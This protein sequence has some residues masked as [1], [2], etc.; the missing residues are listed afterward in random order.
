MK[1]AHVYNIYR[2]MDVRSLQ[3]LLDVLDAE[4]DAQAKNQPVEYDGGR[5]RQ[6]PEC[7]NLR[8]STGMSHDARF[9]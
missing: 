1:T 3:D 8:P 5:R 6:G 2:K 7:A 9:A 4:E